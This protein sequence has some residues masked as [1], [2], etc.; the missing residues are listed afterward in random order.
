MYEDEIS[1][2][3]A[4]EDKTDESNKRLL[5]SEESCIKLKNKYPSIPEEFLSYLQEIGAGT[6]REQQYWIYEDPALHNK[7]ERFSWYKPTDFLEKNYLVIGDDFA[8]NL[9]A[10]DIQNDYAPVLLDHECL[11]E[12]PFDGSIKYFFRE[13]MLLDKDGKDQ[14][15][16]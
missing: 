7:D 14:R 1:F 9:Y 10:L 15:A 12:F 5:F 3:L 6:V 4:V 16:Y 11:E 8:G 13:M 2:L